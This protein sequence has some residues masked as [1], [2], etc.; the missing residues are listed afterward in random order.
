M[1]GVIP[2][3]GSR[4]SIG[5]V[6]AAFVGPAPDGYPPG[7]PGNAPAGGQLIELSTVL[8]NNGAYGI[9]QIIGT[10][11]NFSQTFGGKTTPNNYTP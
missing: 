5:H 10:R 8:G 9:G 11:I 3:T 2:A 7:S 4:I 1:T 6:N